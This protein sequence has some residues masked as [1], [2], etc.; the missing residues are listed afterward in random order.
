MVL[1]SSMVVF[2]LSQKRAFLLQAITKANYQFDLI[3][4]RHFVLPKK[5]KKNKKTTNQAKISCNSL[6]LIFSIQLICF[7]ILVRAVLNNLERYRKSSCIWYMCL[8]S[9]MFFY[10]FFYSLYEKINL[11]LPVQTFLIGLL[12]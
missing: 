1:R 11:S 6:V 2:T 5:K 4:I 3:K 9:D 12:S 10:H 8:N 7:P